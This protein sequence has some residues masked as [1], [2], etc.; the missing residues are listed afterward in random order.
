MF[1]DNAVLL[2]AVAAFVCFGFVA[3][4]YI[5]EE[6][7]WVFIIGIVVFAFALIK[8]F[9]RKQRTDEDKYEDWIV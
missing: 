6:I 3:A 5:T 9:W 8:V 1:A 2:L 7:D 4:I